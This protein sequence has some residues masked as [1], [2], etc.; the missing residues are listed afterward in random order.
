MPKLNHYILF[1]Y[2]KIGSSSR[3]CHLIVRKASHN[4]RP[5]ARE[6]EKHV[7]A[8]IK[9][10]YS[11]REESLDHGTPT[12]PQIEDAISTEIIISINNIIIDHSF[13]LECIAHGGHLVE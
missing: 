8:I 6:G 13:V 11:C 2:C 9:L 1:K 4:C 3:D 5:L 10:F 7:K 12:K